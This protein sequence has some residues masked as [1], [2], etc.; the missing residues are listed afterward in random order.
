ME[1]EGPT[2]TILLP[3]DVPWDGMDTQRNVPMGSPDTERSRWRM[4]ARY[5]Q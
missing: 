3:G 1:G 2:E 4:K 5:I